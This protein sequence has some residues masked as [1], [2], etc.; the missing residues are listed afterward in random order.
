MERF[1]SIRHK[2]SHEKIQLD[3]GL[4]FICHHNCPHR[5]TDMECAIHVQNNLKRNGFEVKDIKLIEADIKYIREH[6]NNYGF[7]R[8]I[9]LNDSIHTRYCFCG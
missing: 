7:C 8:C 4:H 2:T 3:D 5:M 1:G 9:I 6:N